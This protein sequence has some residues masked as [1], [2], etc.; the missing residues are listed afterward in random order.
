MK[1]S[2]SIP[3]SKNQF[4]SIIYEKIIDCPNGTVPILRNTK[5]Y[6]ANAQYFAEKH[7]NPFT[8]ESHGTHVSTQLYP[9]YSIVNS[10]TMIMHIIMI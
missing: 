8:V 3:K 6:V 10:C 1:P 7:F 2:F 9:H 5:E 4:E